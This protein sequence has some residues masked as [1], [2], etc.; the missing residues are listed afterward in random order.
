MLRAADVKRTASQRH[1]RPGEL[2]V[3]TALLAGDPEGPFRL[4][5]RFQCT[6]LQA[7]WLQNR[8]VR[9]APSRPRDV[10]RLLRLL[11]CC[12]W[13]TNVLTTMSQLLLMPR[14]A[15]PIPSPAWKQRLGTFVSDVR[16]SAFCEV[17]GRALPVLWPRTARNVCVSLAALKLL[18]RRSAFIDL[19]I[20]KNRTWL[21]VTGS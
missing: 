19:Q 2:V 7:S 21:C 18:C 12:C 13:M 5:P 14:M 3:C 9:L 4:G 11:S 8:F 15:R 16:W 6:A 17:S 10:P 1:P 20:G